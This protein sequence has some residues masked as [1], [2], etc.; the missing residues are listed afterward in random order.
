M[1]CAAIFTALNAGFAGAAGIVPPRAPT[2]NVLAV[3]AFNTDASHS[4]SF[5]S[6]L[7]A[8]WRW[9]ANQISPN[10]LSSDCVT[11]EVQAT[12]HAH[13]LEHIAGITLPRNFSKL[14]A[15]EQSLVL[16][17]LERVSRGEQ[18]VLGLSRAADT[19]AQR[20]AQLNQDPMLTNL[21]AIPGAN[22]A[23]TA[24][25]AAAV[26]PLDAN[27]SWMYLDGW[28]GKGRTY[29]YTCTSPTARGCW[30]HRNDILV[31]S[32]VLPCSATNCSLVM[33]AG[34]VAV[35]WAKTYNSYT[36]LFVQ[37]V[38]PTPP[39]IYTWKQAV[40]AGAKV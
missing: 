9:N 33:G 36:E 22:G 40:A 26:N 28:A 6:K 34:Y 27:Y 39:M 17:D 14:N 12:N 5:G 11:A 19:M 8:C 29:N 23:W 30:G 21:H 20:G 18:P 3:P 4:Y 31:N 37:V 24:N 2:S 15:N 35:N 32:A 10:A 16:V 38:G 13:R 1:L 7:P 25:W